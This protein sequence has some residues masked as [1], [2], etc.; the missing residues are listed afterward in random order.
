VAPSGLY[1]SNFY[2]SSGMSITVL[3]MTD[4]FFTARRYASVVYA[5]VMCLPVCQC[6][7]S[8]TLRHCIKTAECRIMQI[9]QYDITGT[10]V[11]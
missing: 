5:V 11:F 6:V 9:M 1:A 3:R 2:C 10:L 4:R 8:V 7:L